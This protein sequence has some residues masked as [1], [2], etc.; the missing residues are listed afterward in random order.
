MAL[1]SLQDVTVAFGGPA[2]LDQATLRVDAGERIAL[3]GR[4][5]AGKSTLLRVIHGDVGCDRGEIVRQQGSSV[6]ILA[7][8][9]PRDLAGTIYDE[10]AR[11]LGRPAELLAAYH[12]AATAYAAA[13]AGALR[14]ELDRLER[15]LDLLGGWR[16]HQ[17]V[18]R[19]LS[20]MDLP[21]E[22]NCIG[23][24]AGMKRRV[25]LAKALVGEPDILLLDEP[26]NHLDIEAIDW[27]EEFLLRYDKSLIFVTHD[28]VFLRKL[29]TRIV[30]IDRGALTSWDCDHA[31]YLARKEAAYQAE[32][33]N[34]ELFDK[35]LAQEEAWLRSGIKARRTRNEGRVRALENLREVRR[36]RRDRPGEA[37]MQAVEAGRSGRMVIEAK[38]VAFSYPGGTADIVQGCSAL[39]MRGDKLGIVG[40]NGSGKTTLLRLLL[41]ELPPREGTVRHGTNLEVAYFD[42]LHAQLDEEKSV[43]DNVTDG[44]D[45]VVVGG[46]SRHVLGYL[47]DFLFSPDQARQAVKRLSGG[48]RNRLL[49]A[50]L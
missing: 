37:R 47:Q 8:E 11:G 4:N 26:T 2:V 16:Q 7:Q 41:G 28:R 3:V 20:Q 25:L 42:Q 9:V 40:P 24:S 34:E 29:A 10:V 23:L 38:G 35:R 22:A 1:L 33:R 30:E 43:I 19:V 45:R 12:R 14:A 32:I 46:G 36:D 31:T 13:P 39:V 15:A 50:R 44:S 6:A 21:P 48:E 27:L 5:G 49:L 18:D 17:S